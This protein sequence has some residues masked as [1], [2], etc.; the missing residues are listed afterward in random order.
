MPLT[1][2][3]KK[4]LQD[5]V[6]SKPARTKFSEADAR[7][8]AAL[9]LLQATLTDEAKAQ[10]QAMVQ[11]L[12]ALRALPGKDAAD[13]L[14]LAITH[15]HAGASIAAIAAATP[16]LRRPHAQYRKGRVY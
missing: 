5:F 13:A 15:A 6:S 1:Q 9:A 14:G 4:W 2:G 3:Q 12:L 10:I 11:R 8:E 7:R 16:V